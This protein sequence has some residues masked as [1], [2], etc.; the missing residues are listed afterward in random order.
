MTHKKKEQDK[1]AVSITVNETIL[2]DFT[3]MVEEMKEVCLEHHGEDCEYEHT[4]DS[5]IEHYMKIALSQ[6][7]IAKV[8]RK[9]L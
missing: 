6:W 7:N 8:L 1:L 9:Y 5:E 4:V 3:E 2:A